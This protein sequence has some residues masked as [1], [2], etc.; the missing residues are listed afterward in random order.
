MGVNTG[1][2]LQLMREVINACRTKFKKNFKE[3]QRIRSFKLQKLLLSRAVDE[4]PEHGFEWTLRIKAA[5]GSTQML[6]AFEQVTYQ[7]DT[8]DTSLK[9]T[10]RTMTTHLNMVFDRLAE[11]INKKASNQLW[12]DYNMKASAA[13]ESR[14]EAWESKLLNA[15]QTEAGK[16]A[17]LG[18]LYW[19]RRSMTSGGV[20]TEQTTPARN[21]VYYVN[22][23]GSVVGTM[24]TADLTLAA[25]GRLRTLVATHRGIMDDNCLT[26]LRDCVLDAGFE[27]LDDLMGEKTTMDLVILWDDVFDRAYDDLC[28]ALGGPRKRD[29]F[30]TGFTLE[31]GDKLEL[32]D[33]DGADDVFELYGITSSTAT[34]QVLLGRR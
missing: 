27:Y 13:E 9:V 25:M 20:Y 11:Q 7:R 30:E 5:Q 19:Y 10:P 2:D 23:A 18:L 22:G 33:L 28:K 12:K 3:T 24:A 6:D 29:Y 21:G 34:I 26:T 32:S 31:P 17:F 4:S 14:A 8:Y 1:L 16:D 15:P